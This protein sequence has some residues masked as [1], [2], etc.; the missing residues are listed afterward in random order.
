M[1]KFTVNDETID[2]TELEKYYLKNKKVSI[3]N[4][5]FNEGVIMEIS[6]SKQIK[7]Y[8]VEINEYT[9]YPDLH[10]ARLQYLYYEKEKNDTRKI[11]HYDI[12][13]IRQSYDNYILELNRA[14]DKYREENGIIE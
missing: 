10:R 2:L 4:I 1:F 3:W 14:L 8:N 5:E 11:D 6:C 9:R 7:I 13:N 12:T